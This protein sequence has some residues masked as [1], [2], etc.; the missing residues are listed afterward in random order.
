MAFSVQ[1]QELEKGRESIN[2]GWRQ[3]GHSRPLF[4]YLSS[5]KIGSCKP[6]GGTV[7]GGCY[8]RGSKKS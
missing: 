4:R 3:E 1:K 7:G 5:E 6:R 8:T 2:R